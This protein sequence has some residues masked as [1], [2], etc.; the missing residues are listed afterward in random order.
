MKKSALCFLVFSCCISSTFA[1]EEALTQEQILENKIQAQ[2]DS[3]LGT[4]KIFL[5]EK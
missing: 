2:V 5:S 1:V 3:G 4:I